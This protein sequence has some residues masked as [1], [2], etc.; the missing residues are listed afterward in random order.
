VSARAAVRPLVERWGELQ[1]ALW[2]IRR[3][4]LRPALDAATVHIR[5]ALPADVPALEQLIAG[6]AARG[7]LLP[8]RAD[9][10]Y[11]HIRE[12]QVAV[13]SHGVLGCAGLKIYS[14]ELG[15]VSALAVAERCQGQG[16]GSRLVESVLREAGEL[17]LR[18][19]FAL[20]LQEGFFHRL[21]FTTADVREFPAKIAADCAA[22][23][24]RSACDEIAVVRTLDH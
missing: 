1:P 7:L 3:R 13:D 22:C 14:A 24:R 9:Q 2:P 17:G 18:R 23:P 10:L 5:P 19:V 11:R 12:M 20:T 4:T 16:V 8:R 21:G 15:E 6:Y